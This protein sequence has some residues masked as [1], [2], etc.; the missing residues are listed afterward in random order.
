MHKTVNHRTNACH[1]GYYDSN[2][3]DTSYK[4]VNSDQDGYN[5]PLLSAA[6]PALMPPLITVV[7]LRR[8]FRHTSQSYTSRVLP[9]LRAEPWG[10]RY[11][12][13]DSSALLNPRQTNKTRPITHDGGQDARTY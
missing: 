11:S 10:A 3:F 7:A 9:K 13:L 5:M 4:Y 8:Y 1:W 6:A 12:M 2:I